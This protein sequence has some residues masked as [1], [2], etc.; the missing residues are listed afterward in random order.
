MGGGSAGRDE[1]QGGALLGAAAVAQGFLEAAPDAIVI[2]DAAGLI[3]VVNSQTEKLF[4]YDRSELVGRPI[5]ML[6]PARLRAG[7]VGHRDGFL[8]APKVR[9]MGSG[10]E[11][12]G[13]RKDGTEFSVEISLSPLAGTQG[14]VASAIR[15]ISERKRAED[16]FRGLLESAPD[17]MV[18]VGVDGRIQLVNAQTEKLF[19]YDRA[20]LIG[21]PIECLVPERVRD[22][23]PGF[24]SGYFAGP[25]ARPMGAAQALSGRRKDGSEFEAEISLSPLE[26]KGATV[27]TA[28]IRDITERRRLEREIFER[29]NQDLENRNRRIQE[30]NRMKSEFLAN[31]SHELRTPLNAIIGFA[32]LLF[33]GAVDPE[34]PQH[35]EFLGDILNSG[36]HLLQ[37]IND[38]LDVSKIEVGRLRLRAEHVDANVIVAEVVGSLRTVAADKS[39]A[40]RTHLGAD[41]SDVFLDPSRLKQVLYNYLSNALKFTPDHGTIEVST[42]RVE[43][44]AFRLEVK[45]SG[46]G[47]AQEDIG[48]LFVEFQQLDAGSAKRHGGSGLGLALTKRLVEAHGGSVGV[49]SEVGRGSCFHAIFPFG[50]ADAEVPLGHDG[51][52]VALIVDAHGSAQE[53]LGKVLGNLG[54]AVVGAPNGSAALAHIAERRFDVVLLDMTLP[55]LNAWTVVSALR[56]NEA[57][58]QATVI[59]MTTITEDTVRGFPV[60]ELLDKPLD[61]TRLVQALGAIKR[62]NPSHAPSVL[63]IDDDERDLELLTTTLQR[64]GFEVI[65]ARSGQEG[66]AAVESVKV[67]AV[68]LDLLMPG[69]SGF[70]FV[71]RFRAVPGNGDV[72][73]I[74]WTGKDL[75]EEERS[76]LEADV[77]QVVPK[78]GQRG[79]ESQLRILLDGARESME[80]RRHAER[81]DPH[82]R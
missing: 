69:M 62:K 31:M 82:R 65:S 4:G 59:A 58:R 16:M 18:I 77:R 28:A 40:V 42:A 15:D 5:E 29:R 36:R 61:A 55:D 75:T 48:R 34:S 45:D 12:N 1:V 2:V 64:L 57:N 81:A 66:L 11:L 51:A 67:S 49:S 63:A 17:A 54:Y 30:A 19:G 20:E 78:T 41:L 3:V 13:L 80:R 38:V 47:I 60:H 7:H 25:K 27:V 71:E 10:R 56:E 53:T 26:T 8:G 68:V 35:H 9:A 73:L 24:R 39:I 33:D 52:A 46:I 50:A 70:D 44:G 14:L 72:P 76:R 32:E 23:H 37:L 22:R 79:L 21:Q 74:V 43:P 6:V